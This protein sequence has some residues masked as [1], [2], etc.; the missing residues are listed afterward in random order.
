M[1]F[2]AATVP[3]RMA[4]EPR[5]IP[6]TSAHGTVRW[7][8]PPSRGESRR[9]PAPSATIEKYIGSGS[10]RTRRGAEAP[11]KSTTSSVDG[12]RWAT[13]THASASSFLSCRFCFTVGL[14]ITRRK[15]AGASSPKLTRHSDLNTLDEV[16]PDLNSSLP[17]VPEFDA[18]PI[19][20]E[21][22]IHLP[23][24]KQ[25]IGPS[26]PED[27]LKR[28]IHSFRG[29]NLKNDRFVC[30]PF[31]NLRALCRHPTSALSF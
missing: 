14:T 19:C 2:S 20:D 3:P 15:E 26:R 29:S 10:P 17:R 13:S 21:Y 25:L 5:A 31:L 8:E 24:A 6:T 23:R 11:R 1:T 27:P 9:R 16:P 18:G 7:G 28:I 12:C 22:R 30:R 4:T